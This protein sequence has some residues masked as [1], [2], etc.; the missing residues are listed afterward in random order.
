[1]PPDTYFHIHIEISSYHRETKIQFKG[2]LTL[3]LGIN[4]EQWGMWEVMALCKEDNE[5]AM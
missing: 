1:M 3:G 5:A 4:W 2:H